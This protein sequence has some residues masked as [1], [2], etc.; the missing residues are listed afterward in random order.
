M[1]DSEQCYVVGSGP[2]GISCAQALIAK[3]RKVTILDSGVTLEAERRSALVKIAGSSVSEWTPSVTAVLREGMSSSSSGILLKLAYGSDYPYREVAGST[4]IVCEGPDTRPSYA[5]GGLSTVWGSA[6][7]PYRQHDIADWPIA[8]TDL[9]AGY[10]AVL[11]WMPLSG[12]DDALAEFFPLYRDDEHSLPMSNQASGLLEKLKNNRTDLNGQG[13]FF[14]QSRLA[15]G[16]KCVQC[17]LCIYGCPHNLI[18]SSD[19][20]LQAMM[21]CGRIQYRSGITVQRVAESSSG[22]TIYALDSAGNAVEFTADRVFLGAGLLNTTAILLRSLEQ[23]DKPVE[24]KDSQYYLLPLLRLQGTDGVMQEP[25][26]TLA[27]LFVE[28]FDE[29]VS[30]YTVHLQTYTYN[31]LFRDAV[32]AKLGPV[33][34][35]FPLETFLGRLLLFQGYLHSKHSA[36]ITA[37]LERNGQGDRLRLQSSPIPETKMRVDK[38]SS[39]LFKL[40]G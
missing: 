1:R 32:L 23:F 31:D 34:R 33:A 35:L 13:V 36:P 16:P 28:I 15:V 26:H 21:A 10:R 29:S 18:Y 14:G 19:Q 25:L 12:V 39:K 4:H 24:I 17:G 11:R 9:E 22:V 8:V 3:G 6:V 2:A 37:T 30:P 7:L 38:L 20:T 27:Q 40:A 5:R